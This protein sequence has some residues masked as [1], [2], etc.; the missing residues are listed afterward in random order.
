MLKPDPM[1]PSQQVFNFAWILGSD[2]SDDTVRELDEFLRVSSLNTD[3]SSLNGQDNSTLEALQI[4]SGG[5]DSGNSGSEI[6]GTI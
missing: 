2:V 6:N 3:N 4:M 5:N 1:H